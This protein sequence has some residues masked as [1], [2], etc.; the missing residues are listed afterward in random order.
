[1][2]KKKTPKKENKWYVDYCLNEEE[3][4]IIRIDDDTVRLVTLFALGD[5]GNLY[6]EAVE[7]KDL[8]VIYQDTI[9]YWCDY[10]SAEVIDG[11]DYDTRCNLF[12][13]EDGNEN[14]DIYKHLIREGGCFKLRNCINNEIYTLTKAGLVDGIEQA[15]HE[16]YSQHEYD[17]NSM[18]EEN[19]IE[20][21]EEYGVYRF[22]YPDDGGS[23]FG[24]MAF[25]FALFDD[26]YYNRDCL[27]MH[28]GIRVYIREYEPL[29]E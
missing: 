7:Y 8:S 24:D 6:D 22:S 16:I 2:A 15:F 5:M 26:L 1:M 9:A 10:I 12:Y 21:D 23:D 13:D 25:Q 11:T 17:Y 19:Y 28:G 29:P 18:I 27:R 3:N 4:I 14:F 20:Y